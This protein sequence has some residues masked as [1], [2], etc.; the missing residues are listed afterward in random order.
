M[1]PSTSASYPVR[2]AANE[3]GVDYALALAFVDAPTVAA[4]G[5]IA[6]AMAEQHGDPAMQACCGMLE[7]AWFGRRLRVRRW[8]PATDGWRE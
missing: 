6:A 7:N 5:A 8:A 2:G 1:I 3:S 4:A